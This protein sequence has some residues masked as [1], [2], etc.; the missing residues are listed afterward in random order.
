MYSN[1]IFVPV[2]NSDE[3]HLKFRFIVKKTRREMINFYNKETDSDLFLSKR[4]LFPLL[5]S[6]LNSGRAFLV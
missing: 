2:K 1:T 5:T 6:S 4:C 3:I